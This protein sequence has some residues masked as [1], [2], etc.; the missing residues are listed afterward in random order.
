M[1]EEFLVYFDPDVEYTLV[2]FMKQ[3]EE[4]TSGEILLDRRKTEAFLFDMVTKRKLDTK[5][6]VRRVRGGSYL[7]KVYFLSKTA[8]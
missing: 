6:S 2:E 4:V 8:Q 1:N 7:A 5:G 3:V